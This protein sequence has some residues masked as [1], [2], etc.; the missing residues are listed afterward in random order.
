MTAIHFEPAREQDAEALV[1]LR[2]EA[3]RPSLERIGRFDPLRARARFLDGFVPPCA[4][5][6]VC[7]GERVGFVVVKEGVGEW[8]LDHLYIRPDRQGQ[9]IGHA[10]LQSLFAE[11][12]AAGRPLR[13]GALRGSDSNRFYVRHG[14]KPVGE[15]E[16]DI[17]YLR[18]PG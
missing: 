9:G 4:R 13:V 16:F 6:I 10:V 15:S 3:M 11:A 2:I 5:H 8:L 1:S 12:D 17:Y 18:H 14:F 7:D